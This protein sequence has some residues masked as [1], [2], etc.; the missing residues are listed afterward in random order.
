MLIHKCLP[1]CHVSNEH[2]S[3][4]FK[5]WPFSIRSAGTD[6][7]CGRQ[8]PH[9]NGD[10]RA[11]KPSPGGTCTCPRVCSVLGVVSWARRQLLPGGQREGLCGSE[12]WNGVPP[13]PGQWTPR[14]AR[15]GPF[16]TPAGRRLG[17]RAAPRAGAASSG[18]LGLPASQGQRRAGDEI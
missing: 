17:P 5:R 2:T 9:I 13:A 14:A 15:S 12:A 7:A 4:Y 1:F 10:S 16:L 11:V 6:P 18:G 3:A 8:A